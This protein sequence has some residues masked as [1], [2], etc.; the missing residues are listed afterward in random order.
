MQSPSGAELSYSSHSAVLTDSFGAQAVAA[1][2][3]LLGG[4]SC[5]EH[6]TLVLQKL[7]QLSIHLRSHLRMQILLCKALNHLLIS[8]PSSLHQTWEPGS[9]L[10][11]LSLELS[12]TKLS[13]VEQVLWVRRRIEKPESCILYLEER[14]SQWCWVTSHFA[15]C[16]HV[17][18]SLSSAGIL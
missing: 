10:E 18:F 13:A 12:L 11:E 5:A 4:R 8:S 15:Q 7:H 1:H 3:S 17:Y 9:C 2:I 6:T 16:W 14:T